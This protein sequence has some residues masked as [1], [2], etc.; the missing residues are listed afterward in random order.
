MNK[1][2]HLLACLAEECAEVQHAVAKALR[3]GLDDGYLGAASTNAQDIAREFADVLAV[4]EMLEEDGA[5]ERAKTG[6]VDLMHADTVPLGAPGP[7]PHPGPRGFDTTRAP[8]A[9]GSPSGKGAGPQRS[10]ATRARVETLP[11]TVQGLWDL[12]IAAER[13]ISSSIS[14]RSATAAR[15]SRPLARRTASST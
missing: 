12:Q 4:V 7:A 15:G 13:S 11:R 1:T 10:E 9:V 3:F 2:E 5:L 6:G 14:E 8:P